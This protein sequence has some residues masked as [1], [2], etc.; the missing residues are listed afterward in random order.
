[1]RYEKKVI[2][3]SSVLAALLLIW[4]AGLL[5]SPER[6]AARSESAHLLAGKSAEV[7][8]VSLKVPGGAAL[9]F[10]KSGAD[11]LLVDGGAK[12]P[13]QAKRLASFADD[14]AAIARLRVVARSKDS[15]SGFQLDEAQAKHAILKDASG[16]TLADLYFGGYGPTGSETYIRKAGPPTSPTWR[17]RA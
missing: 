9:D 17:T 12:L 16:K 7:A 5:F 15:W 4:G 2:V 6:V 1:M 3:L 11:W 14:I 10:Q 8:A 13:A